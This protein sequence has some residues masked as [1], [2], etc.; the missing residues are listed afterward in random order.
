MALPRL[1]RT[2][3]RVLV[4][5]AHAMTTTRTAGEWERELQDALRAT[6]PR[7]DAIIVLTDLARAFDGWQRRRDTI[8]IAEAA[9]AVS[10]ALQRAR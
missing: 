1:V 6:T 7:R 4:G 2:A 3:L 5:Q 8:A 9:R 10:E